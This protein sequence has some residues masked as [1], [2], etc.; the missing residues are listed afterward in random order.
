MILLE[1]ME[2]YFN[3]DSETKLQ[4]YISSVKTELMYLIFKEVNE[5]IVNNSYSSEKMVTY[6][7]D[8][9]GLTE[10]VNI[11][12][13]SLTPDE[14]NLIKLRFGFEDGRTPSLIDLEKELSVDRE[15]LRKMEAKAI[16]KLRH[17]SRSEFLRVYID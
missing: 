16:R 12:L 3:N 4:N 5:F 13:S 9:I 17:P 2:E 11:I 15:T 10:R 8:S 1:K 14:V 6:D 7:F